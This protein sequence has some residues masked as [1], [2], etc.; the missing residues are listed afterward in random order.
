MTSR[1]DVTTFVPLFFSLLFLLADPLSALAITPRDP[2]FIEQTY[3]QTIAAPAAWDV[4]TG[5]SSVVVAVLDTG[6]DLDHP[7]LKGNIW[8]NDDEEAGNGVDDDDNG[9]VDDVNGWDFVQDDNTVTPSPSGSEVAVSHGTVIAGIIGARGDNGVGVTGVA[10]NVKIMSVR[11]LN[12][13]GSGDSATAANAVDYAVRNG[14]D[15]INL[16]FA[17]DTADSVLRTAIE[18]AY[19]AGVIVVAAMGN[20]GRDTDSE[21]VYPAC[22]YK[23]TQDWVIGVAS[24]SGTDTASTFS[25]YGKTCTDISAPGEDV[26]TTEYYD[27]PA[28][29]TRPYGGGWSG[30]SM[31]SP[32]VAGAVA[33]LRAAFPTISV[34]NVRNAL[35]LSVDPLHVTL[36]QRGKYGAG[37]LNVANAL[38]VA[39]Q[40]L[41]VEPEADDNA[42]GDV[43]TE[44]SPSEDVLVGDGLVPSLAPSRIV[45]GA[46]SGAAPMVDVRR[47]DGTEVAQF[48]AYADGFMG[49]LHVAVGDV[50]G[51]GKPNV[52]TGAGTGGGPHVRVFTESGALVSQFFP[53]ATSGR[54]GVEV[55]T[56]DVDGDDVDEIVTAVGAGVSHDVVA[57][58]ARGEERVRFT[59]NAFA[60]NAP[61]RVAVGDVDGDGRGEFLVTAG[62]GFSPKIA[63]YDTD[64]TFLRE[65]APY[66]T[67]FMGGV[68]VAAGDVNGDGTD[69]IIT[70]TGDGGGPQVRVFNAIGAVIGSFFAFD[71]SSR[72]GVHVASAD[73]NRDSVDEI[74]AS[75]GSSS[76]LLKILTDKGVLISTFSVNLTGKEGTAIAAW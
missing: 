51:D 8:S 38:T 37:R 52:V 44:A 18:R 30:T 19:K 13:S 7:D 17:G 25:N 53:Y 76:T 28:G 32:I 54:G 24:S 15:I 71:E 69:E 36:S 34:D 60:A 70:G 39:A 73:T 62:A 1:R 21:A 46:T 2:H 23:G 74:I 63:V 22:L 48:L 75:P 59:V 42:T 16:S 64:G 20:E 56:G 45:T 61:L 6:V 68:Y 4:E 41:G 65:F 66:G 31:A 5:S 72:Y 26:Y 35:K 12:A 40:L 29:F 33:L 50:D 27:K 67:T 43:A 3:L 11:M 57:W 14:A 10:W 47:P 49:G 55:A 58:S 9:F